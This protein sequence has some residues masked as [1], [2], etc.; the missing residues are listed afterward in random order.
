MKKDNLELWNK[1]CKTDPKHTKLVGYGTHKFTAI[2]AAYQM[3]MA[4][5]EFGLYGETWGI[6]SIEYT[7]IEGLTNNIQL[8]LGNA[9]F[10]HPNGSFPIS[11]SIE[12]QSYSK[13][14]DTNNVDSDF[15]KKLETDIT[16]KALSKLGFNAD[17]FLGMYDDNKY[18]AQVKA[19]FSEPKKATQKQYPASTI[20]KAFDKAE[21]EERVK[22]VWG[23][24]KQSNLQDNP[25]V[26][27]AIKAAQQRLGIVKK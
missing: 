5:K 24:T 13:K 25:L 18:V 19:E 22:E 6:M 2:N 10:F 9:V 12:L 23:Y 15:A 17:V 27:D 14:Y 4:T 7:R 11:S 26:L 1:V 8:M 21:T 3:R 16:T 20:I